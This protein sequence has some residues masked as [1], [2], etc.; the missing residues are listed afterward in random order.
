MTLNGGVEITHA[1]PDRWDVRQ[2]LIE[3]IDA[4][5][6]IQASHLSFREAAAFW[7]LEQFRDRAALLHLDRIRAGA[8]LDEGEFQLVDYVLGSARNEPAR[9]RAKASFESLRVP[10][11]LAVV[12]LA[13]CAVTGL[14]SV[15]AGLGQIGLL[16][17]LQVG[18]PVPDADLATHD[19]LYAG[20]GLLQS[21]GFLVSA[22][23]FL[24]WVHRASC[25]QVALGGHPPVHSPGWAIGGWFIPL[26]H[27]VIPYQ[28]VA[29]IA[30]NAAAATGSPPTGNGL[31][32]I[33]WAS[34]LLLITTSQ[35]DILL[36]APSGQRSKDEVIEALLSGSYAKLAFDIASIASAVC[37]TLVVLRITAVQVLAHSRQIDGHPEEPTTAPSGQRHAVGWDTHGFSREVRR[38]S[39]DL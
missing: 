4:V 3:V 7:Q 18:V 31:V 21:L 6:V 19:L 1:S 10:A 11:T 38:R 12:G 25:N 5:D 28:V 23:T 20:I 9:P 26:I 29:E 14:A 30:R 34:W 17:K 32:R 8:G 35:F 13:L 39:R 36:A 15:Y 33:W 2:H 37:A 22:V 16:H 24:V 27:L